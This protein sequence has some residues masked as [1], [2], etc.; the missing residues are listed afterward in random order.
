MT[1]D[2]CGKHENA[3]EALAVMARSIKALV[4]RSYGIRHHC[5]MDIPW[6]DLLDPDQHQWFDPQYDS[7]LAAI[8][9]MEEP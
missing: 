4:D 9:A 6:E 1:N 8:D 7:A 5:G 3:A 2:Q